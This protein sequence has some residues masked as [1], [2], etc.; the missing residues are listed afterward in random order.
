MALTVSVSIERNL[1][2][3]DTGKAE[4]ATNDKLQ[5]F[6]GRREE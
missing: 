5:N 3:Q 1:V 6:L 2:N 4:I